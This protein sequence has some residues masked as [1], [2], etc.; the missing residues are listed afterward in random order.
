MYIQYC[1]SI[2]LKIP[3]LNRLTYAM[4]K[5]LNNMKLFKNKI[6]TQQNKKSFIRITYQGYRNSN[7]RTIFMIK[8][9]LNVMIKAKALVSLF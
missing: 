2:Y 5:S 4:L 3:K 7:N 9:T 8:L 1:I 6:V